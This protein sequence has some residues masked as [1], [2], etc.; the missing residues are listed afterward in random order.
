MAM[1]DRHRLISSPCGQPGAHAERYFHADAESALV[2]LRR[3]AKRTVDFLYNN[4]C[5]TRALQ[6]NFI[7]SPDTGLRA[8][9][10]SVPGTH[11]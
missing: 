4:L 6:S 11:P 5:A 3:F 9:H 7:D 10:G 2:K 8:F 1:Q